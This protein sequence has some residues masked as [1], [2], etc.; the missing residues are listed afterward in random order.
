MFMQYIHAAM[1][2][3]KYRILEDKNYYGEIPGL[4]GIWASEKSLED[5]R[6][7]LQ[8]VLEEWVLLKVQYGDKLPTIHGKRLKLPNLAHANLS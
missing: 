5:C 6:R 2:Q 4:R 1:G 8:E 3:A 7:V